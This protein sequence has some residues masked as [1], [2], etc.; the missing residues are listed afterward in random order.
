M[1][2]PKN[3]DGL[4]LEESLK[5]EEGSQ[6]NEIQHK[7]KLTKGFYLGVFTVTQEQWQ[8][9]MGNNPSQFKGEKNLPVEKVSWEDCQEFIKKTAGKGPE[10]LPVAE[11]EPN[12]ST[13][14]VPEQQRHSILA[15]PS[16]RSEDTFTSA[17]RFPMA[18]AR[19]A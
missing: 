17:A 10:A 6:P 14:A 7:V 16:R 2:S 15:Q 9:V 13:P 4:K 12:G 11:R 19:K 18:K 5:V 1:G 3:G 8:E